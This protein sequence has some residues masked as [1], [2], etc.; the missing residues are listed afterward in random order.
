MAFARVLEELEAEAACEGLDMRSFLML[1]MQRIT[2]SIHP[3]PDWDGPSMGGSRYPLLID[4]ILQRIEG[5]DSEPYR[6]AK[7]ALVLANKVL[8]PIHQ[9]QNYANGTDR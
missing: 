6:N 4:A 9:L 8:C 5:E 1:P 3:P 2:R 7:K